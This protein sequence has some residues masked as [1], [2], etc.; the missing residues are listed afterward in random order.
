M[1]KSA[2]RTDEEF[3]REMLAGVNP[4]I[5]SRLRVHTNLCQIRYL[6]L[7]YCL[8]AFLF[9]KIYMQEFPPK[10]KLDPKEFGSHTSTITEGQMEE[11]MNGLTVDQVITTLHFFFFVFLFM[12]ENYSKIK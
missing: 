9:T 1:D 8:L 4:V 3:G 12:L 11:N 5:I 2:W 7:F 6:F 10:S